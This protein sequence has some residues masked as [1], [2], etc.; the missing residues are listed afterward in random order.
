[1]NTYITRLSEY[2][3]KLPGIG[4]R[5]AYRFACHLLNQDKTFLDNF[6]GIISKLKENVIQCGEC[7]RFFLNDNKNTACEICRDKNR[8]KNLL[9]V[10]ERDIDL[11]NI[12][13][14]GFY[15]G[16]Y[17]VLGGLVPLLGKGLPKEVRAKELFEKVKNAARKNE[18]RE[19]IM[20]FNATQEGDNTNRYIEK[21]LEPILEKKPIKI[22]HLGR[23]LS[24][25]TELEYSDKETIVNALKNR[26]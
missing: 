6:A 11:E 17:F 8:D 3:E 21:I 26:K 2:F 19:I 25:G 16:H 18:L 5:Q 9:L 22:T 13:K 23:G 12:E 10:A 15:N 1:M 7:K 20:A 4:P 24:T 14:A